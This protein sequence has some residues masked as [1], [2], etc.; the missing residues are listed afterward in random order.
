MDNTATAKKQTPP[1]APNIRRL[2]RMQV[3]DGGAARLVAAILHA[4]D[5]NDVRTGLVRLSDA[6]L[7]NGWTVYRWLRGN[8]EPRRRQRAVLTA[9]AVRLGLDP[10]NLPAVPTEVEV[11]EEDVRAVDTAPVEE[12]G[13]DDSPDTLEDVPAPVREASADEA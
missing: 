9:E 10:D 5:P 3:G 4:A 12:E 6:C 11:P 1:D 7:V 2:S 13:D 8:H